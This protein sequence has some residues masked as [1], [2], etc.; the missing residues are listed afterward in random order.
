MIDYVYN[1]PDHLLSWAFALTALGLVVAILTPLATLKSKEKSHEKMVTGYVFSAI[2]LTIAF[3]I[4][5]APALHDDGTKGEYKVT[6]TVTQMLAEPKENDGALGM[7]AV[8]SIDGINDKMFSVPVLADSEIV[9][10]TG[11]NVELSCAGDENT[12]DK[13]IMTCS[14]VSV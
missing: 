13:S 12:M 9:N 11:K 6:G 4:V 14:V 7:N 10:V 1:S 2:V 3:A 5:T 8:L